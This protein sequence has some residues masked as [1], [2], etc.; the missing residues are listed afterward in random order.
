MT[1]GTPVLVGL[2][3]TPGQKKVY[4]MRIQEGI[5][6]PERQGLGP[7]PCYPPE[8]AECDYD[9]FA[10]VIRKNIEENTTVDF[11]L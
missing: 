7:P 9:P 6:K 1:G 3:I 8:E 4:L 5:C 2:S 11:L 10:T